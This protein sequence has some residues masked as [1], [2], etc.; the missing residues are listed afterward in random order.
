MTRDQMDKLIRSWMEEAAAMIKESFKT[1]LTI[2]IKSDR[3][4]L[5]TNMDKKIEQFLIEKIR[6]NF[7][8]DRI[9]GEEGYG[10]KIED[11]VGRVWIIDPIDGTLNFVKQQANFAIMIGVYQ[12]GEGR[13][14]YIYDVMAGEFYWAIAGEGA[15]L[16]GNPL[17]KVADIELREGLVA[18]SSGVF[19]SDKYKAKEIV[20]GSSGLRMVGSAGI[21]TVHVAAGRLVAYITHRLQPWD[22]AAGKVIAE[23][24]GLVY[25]QINGE[26]VDLLQQNATIIAT[27]TA[28]KEILTNYL[29]GI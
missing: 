4:D 29:V 17:P 13:M 9:L 7:P 18:L 1:T 5:V 15:Y 6:S 8:D 22:M 25:T 16:N 20:R 26:P 23:E 21:E 2:E 27:P 11:L 28:H 10:D 24:L 3:N 14:G 12:D 19:S